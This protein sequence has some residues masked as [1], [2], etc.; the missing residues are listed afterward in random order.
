MVGVS[1]VALHMTSGSRRRTV[2]DKQ[3]AFTL[4]QLLLGGPYA[5]QVTQPGYRPCVTANLFISDDKTVNI[6]YKLLAK[7][8]R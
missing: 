5:L 7:A 4:P 2:T 1:V 6:D 3:G 8:K